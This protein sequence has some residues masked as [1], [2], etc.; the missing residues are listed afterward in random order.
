MAGSQTKLGAAARGERAGDDP[1]DSGRS[2]HPV[3]AAG[4]VVAGHGVVWRHR[5]SGLCAREVLR[6]HVFDLTSKKA[7]G[8]AADLWDVRLRGGPFH[9]G[10]G[11]GWIAQNYGWNTARWSVVAAT[12]NGRRA[13][14]VLG[15]TLR[16][17]GKCAGNSDG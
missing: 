1:A 14:G 15:G 17:G 12:G 4:N 11:R 6:R 9:P 16:P 7:V 2:R 5:L 10:Q 13:V 3:Y 8:T